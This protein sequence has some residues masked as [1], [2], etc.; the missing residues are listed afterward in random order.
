MSAVPLIIT[1]Y[2]SSWAFIAIVIAPILIRID[3]YNMVFKGDDGDGSMLPLIITV[4]PIALLIIVAA[5]IASAFVDNK[6][7]HVRFIHM[8]AKDG[9]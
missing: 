5:L 8:V 7:W 4:P 1:I 2:V 9:H 3:A 6:G